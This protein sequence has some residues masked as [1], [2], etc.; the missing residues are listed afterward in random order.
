MSQSIDCGISYECHNEWYIPRQLE[1]H[2]NH[3][4]ISFLLHSEN[5]RARFLLRG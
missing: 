2:P 3:S 1:L 5:L 4:L